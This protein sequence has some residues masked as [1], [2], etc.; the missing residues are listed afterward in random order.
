ML[1]WILYKIHVPLFNAWCLE[2]IVGQYDITEV[3]V[4]ITNY[5]TAVDEF[6]EM[7]N[8]DACYNQSFMISS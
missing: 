1:L 3:K 8:A 5:T 6:C 4:N 7:I 2:G